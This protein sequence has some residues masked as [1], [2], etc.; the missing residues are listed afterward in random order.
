[1]RRWMPLAM[2]L[3][4]GIGCSEPTRPSTQVR[5]SVPS[6]SIVGTIVHAGAV[7]WLQFPLTV[8]IENRGSVTVE[9][10]VCL[11]SIEG[12]DGG[13]WSTVWSPACFVLADGNGNAEVAPGETRAFDLAVVAA[14]A[15]PGGPAWNSPR[16]DG[17]YR[18]RAILY[19]SDG[20]PIDVDPSN[21]FVLRTQ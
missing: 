1:M 21:E 4:C 3:A 7:D 13:N 10:T 6:D 5:V 19:A 17:T 18:F 11:S 20:S 9:Y 8:A 15:G 16:I 12:Y 2:A 14:V